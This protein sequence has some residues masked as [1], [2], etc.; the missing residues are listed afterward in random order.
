M[1][2]PNAMQFW[3]EFATLVNSMGMYKSG[4]AGFDRTV[5]LT[6]YNGVKKYKHQLKSENISVDFP[7]VSMMAAGHPGKVIKMLEEEKSQDSDGFISRYILVCA[8]P[9]RNSLL[10]SVVYE[11]PYE[12]TH[13]LFAIKHFHKSHKVCLK[14][15][16]T[17]FYYIY[18]LPF[19]L[20][21]M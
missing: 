14:I 5:Y 17:L 13:L 1:I 16:N 11:H 18:K 7:R 12:L 20:N 8:E 19:S 6:L 4:N 9:V 15:I 21:T 10:N 2:D 3:D